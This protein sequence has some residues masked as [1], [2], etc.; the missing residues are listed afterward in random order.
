MFA[1]AQFLFELPVEVMKE[2]APAML[3]SLIYVIM[4]AA[5]FCQQAAIRLSLG[6]AMLV[7]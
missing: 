4:W 5:L 3:H 2:Y 6:A 7:M 1:A